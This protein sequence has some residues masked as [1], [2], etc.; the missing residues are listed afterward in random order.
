MSARPS[1]ADRAELFS[2]IPIDVMGDDRLTGEDLRLLIAIGWHDRFGANGRGCYAKHE[3]LAEEANMDLT[4]IS[5]SAANLVAFGYITSERFSLDRRRR[6]YRLIYKE[7]KGIVG[8]YANENTQAD[9]SN[10][11]LGESAIFQ[12]EILGSQKEEVTDSQ[13]ESASQYI[14]LNSSGKY[15]VETSLG[16]NTNLPAENTVERN[17]TTKWENLKPSKTAA[18]T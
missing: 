2:P 1:G 10:E 18:S 16:Q 13:Q 17:P 3:S 7:K 14:L 8:K 9:A 11:I 5:R 15:D 4:S 6:L 12:P